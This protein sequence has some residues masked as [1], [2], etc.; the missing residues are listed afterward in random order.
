VTENITPAD[1]WWR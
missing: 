1:L